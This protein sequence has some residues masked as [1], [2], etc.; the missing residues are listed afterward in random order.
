MHAGVLLHAALADKALLAVLALELLGGV[1]QRPVHLQAVL[2]GEGL[3]AHLAR[4]RPHAR[5]VQHV[6]PQRVQLGQRLAADVA[7]K[8]P[9]GVRRQRPLVQVVVARRRL[10]ERRPLAALLLVSRQVGPQR[11]RV[12]ELFAAQLPQRKHGG[13]RSGRFLPPPP[14]EGA[15]RKKNKGKLTLHL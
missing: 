9:L 15:E 12:L 2:V 5:V 7:H 1:V 11:G 14:Q 3:V 8:L 10:A 13:S 4:V 6:D